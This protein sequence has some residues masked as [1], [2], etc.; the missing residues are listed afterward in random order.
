MRDDFFA[1]PLDAPQR[2]ATRRAI[3]DYVL[4]H[5]SQL[6]TAGHLDEAYEAFK[7]ALVLF[8]PTELRHGI[9]AS[10]LAQAAAEL[11]RGF[12]QRGA[13]QETLVLLAVQV[14]N[15]PK[16][17]AATAAAA[18]M[19]QLADWLVGGGGNTPDPEGRDRLIEDLEAVV[20]AWPSTQVAERLSREYVARPG[21]PSMGRRVH[22]NGDL[23]ALLS[24][25]ARPAAY[26]LMRLY[27]RTSEP[28]D[29]IVALAKLPMAGDVA[30]IEALVTRLAA[31]NAQPSD[32]IAVATLLAQPGHGDEDVAAR[33]CLDAANRFPTASEPRV[34]AGKLALGMRRLALSA[35]EFAEALHL[36]PSRAEVWEALAVVYQARLAEQV[37][38][39]NVDLTALD[40]ELGRLDQFHTDAAKK[41]GHA[42]HPT[43]AGALFEVGRGYYNAGRLAEARRYLDKSLAL[44]ASAP[45]LEIEAQIALK[46]GDPRS[47]A[48]MLER[49]INLPKEDR[50]EQL[51]WRAKLRRLQADAFDAIGETRAGSDTRKSALTDWGVLGGMPL[52]PDIAA[53]AQT[54]RAKLFYALGERDASLEAF[55][56]A[57]DADPDRESTYADAIAFLVPR[58]ELDEALDAYHRALGRA[59]VTDYMKT[60]CSLWILDLLRRAGQPEDPLARAYLQG[61][62]GG[63]WPDELARWAT[64]RQT[65][66]QLVAQADTTAHKAE[67]AFY[68][69]MRAAASGH[70]DEAK[71]LWQEVIASDMLGFFEFDMASYYLNRGDAPSTPVLRSH[72]HLKSAAAPQHPDDG[73]I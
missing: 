35:R 30:Q 47:A 54:E 71:R 27:L 70:R 33:V 49:A 42:L 3:L 2:P 9:D 18:R 51:F 73:S 63:K 20:R 72:E 4:A 45:A 19:R 31:P 64:G 32:A 15:D 29:A 28:G 22:G 48:T 41:L 16:S 69:A 53:E 56:R 60:Y 55:E 12:R 24:A 26:D 43:M 62:D 13:H 59:E 68:R 11:E 38:D 40:R 25:G 5:V 52:N 44:E 66:A 57:I 50:P 14:A 23:Q 6:R 1:L 36:D 61:L 65:D 46:K 37:A 67:C 8:D 34:C 21:G 10:A 58:G 39:P 7:A 17:A